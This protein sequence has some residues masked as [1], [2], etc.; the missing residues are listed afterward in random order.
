[1][2]SHS[3]RG[4]LGSEILWKKYNS[5][6]VFRNKML[7]K[8]K[9]KRIINYERSEKFFPK[10]TEHEIDIFKSRLCGFLAADGSVIIR[11]EAGT[12]RFHYDVQFYPDHY[13]LVKLYEEAFK[14][15]YGKELNIKQKHNFFFVRASSK[16]AAQNLASLANFNSKNWTIPKFLKTKELKKVW[17]KAYF[18]CD[19][20]VCKNYVQV[21][22][23]NKTGLEKMKKVLYEFGIKSK[24]YSY[25]RQQTAWSTNYL[26]N[27]PRK[28]EMLKFML[29]IGFDHPL[30]C[31]KLKEF[32]NLFLG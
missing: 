32:T 13:T 6:E 4:K 27:I 9:E 1:M 12:N 5:N 24:I 2:L 11:K 21:Q 17:L 15:V 20:Y 26:L 25:R 19:G 30:K 10:L 7:K 22:S 16:F 29:E 14:A 18:D 3:Q 8:W 31:A 23:V 28:N